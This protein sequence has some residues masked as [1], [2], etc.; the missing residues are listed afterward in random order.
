MPASPGLATAAHSETSK[1]AVVLVVLGVVEQRHAAVLEVLV[2]GFGHG[3]AVPRKVDSSGSICCAG[4]L[5]RVG[6]P[7]G[8]CPRS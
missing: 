2:D 3:C 5:Y 8:A 6:D 7:T 1:E 4:H